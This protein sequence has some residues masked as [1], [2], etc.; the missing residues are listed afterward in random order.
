MGHLYYPG[1]YHPVIDHV[2]I[3]F[4]WYN[5]TTSV[6]SC[7]F[8]SSALLFYLKPKRI[9]NSLIFSFSLL[10]LVLFKVNIAAFLSPIVLLLLFHD[11]RTREKA[12]IIYMITAVLFFIVLL[13]FRI[14][15]Y[16][17]VKAYYGAK[18]IPSEPG[19]MRQFFWENYSDEVLATYQYLFPVIISFILLFP[20]ILINISKKA[21]RKNIIY[22]LFCVIGI[23]LCF[24]G[25]VTNNDLNVIDIPI[26]LLSIYFLILF[27]VNNKFLSGN[28]I[29]MVSLSFLLGMLLLNYHSLTY[30]KD[31]FRVWVSG[32]Y[33][34]H[35]P[36]PAV[37]FPVVSTSFFRGFMAGPIFHNILSNL[38]DTYNKYIKNTDQ[39]DYHVLFGPRLDFAYAMYKIKP[40]KNLPIW[41]GENAFARGVPFGYTNRLIE[42]F[43]K[44]DIKIAIFGANSQNHAID[45][46]FYPEAINQ[47][48]SENYEV[49]YIG[50][51][52]VFTYPGWKIGN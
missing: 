16:F 40:P 37:L 44:A 32:Y 50:N 12:F 52:A 4:W 18:N 7:L 9:T 29:R 46:T 41:W 24:Y 2:L 25:Q 43:Q 22:V 31:K 33:I 47:Y 42:N 34:Y 17:F 36:P 26:V 19:S 3:S 48:L 21:S 51:L 27:C 28:L 1:F 20:V 49:N 38:D 6:V 10:L 39:A 45:F 30:A 8:I 15:P 14:D 23:F 13:L 35:E 5:Q 11:K